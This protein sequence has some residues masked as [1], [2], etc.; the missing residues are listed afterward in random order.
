[1]ERDQGVLAQLMEVRRLIVRTGMSLEDALGLL[2]DQLRYYA[3]RE[4]WEEEKKH[5]EGVVA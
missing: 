1:M 2:V 3:E 5:T 4:R